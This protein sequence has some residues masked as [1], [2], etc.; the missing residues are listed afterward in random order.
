[1]EK[2]HWKIDYNVIEKIVRVKAIHRVEP[3]LKI[4]CNSLKIYLYSCILNYESEIRGERE[5]LLDRRM[6]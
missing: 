5:I 6:E 3:G 4:N 2:R 1:M